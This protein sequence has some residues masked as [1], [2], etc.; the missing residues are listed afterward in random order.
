MKKLP[1]RVARDVAK[2]YGQTQVIV[3]CWDKEAHLTHTVSYGVTVD[4][5]RQAAQGANLV[6]QA[7]GFPDKYCHAKPIR[8]IKDEAKNGIIGI[9]LATVLSL[10]NI[11]KHLLKKFAL[12]YK[13]VCERPNDP[14]IQGRYHRIIEEINNHVEKLG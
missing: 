2:E 5:C 10:A 14:I 11:S 9:D 1:I 13:E 8:Q 4:D 6:R 12:A 3:V 7:L